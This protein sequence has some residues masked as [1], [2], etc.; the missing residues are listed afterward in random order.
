MLGEHMMH[1]EHEAHWE[2]FSDQLSFAFAI[3]ANSDS[4][5]EQTLDKLQYAAVTVF[6][7]QLSL[8]LHDRPLTDM[9]RTGTTLQ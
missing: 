7:E 3:I 6:R 4:L 1:D 9:E 8:I 5:S 2:R